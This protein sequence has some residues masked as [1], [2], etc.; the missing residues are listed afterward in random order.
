LPG[1]NVSTMSRSKIPT[2]GPLTKPP[3]PTQQISVTGPI[4]KP[5]ISTPR[6]QN[7]E[8]SRTMTV[9]NIPTSLSDIPLDQKRRSILS[10]ELVSLGSVMND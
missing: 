5:V 9:T 3:M 6:P 2:T 4:T 1:V 8:V 10:E 7:P